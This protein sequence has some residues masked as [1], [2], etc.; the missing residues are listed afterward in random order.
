MDY[1]YTND[2]EWLPNQGQDQAWD[3]RIHIAAN[4]DLVN[5]FVVITKR[6]VILIDTLLN[7]TT[8]QKLVDYAQPHLTNR[9][10]LIIN[11][12]ADWDHAWGNQLFNGPSAR[13]PAPI[14]AHEQCAARLGDSDTQATLQALR[15]KH[16]AIFNEVAITAPTL[17]FNNQLVINGGDLTLHL[18]PTPG[19][20]PDH[21][22][23]HIP[24]ISTLFAGDAAEQPF[25]I[26]HNSSDLPTLRAS[27]AKMAALNAQNVLYCHA[28]PIIGP[29]LLQ[30]NIAYY[31]ALE[32][33]CRTAIARNLDT[34]ALTNAELPAALQCEFAQ[35]APN[36]G[37][38]ENIATEVS[39]ARQG[40]QLRLMLA[41]LKNE[42]L[43]IG[44]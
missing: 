34:S 2:V 9:Q 29:R 11:T 31:N 28:P 20:T 38:W 7:A 8:A 19:H 5:V 37:A 27:L 10:L 26:V 44:D 14:I 40:E 16:P 25:P 43:Q 33:A 18:F 6:Y 17:T 41:W 35:I 30:D 4:A 15:D 12:H 24:E 1:T 32:S 21:I 22:A 39:P 36:T 13:Y 3:Q 42:E 23:I